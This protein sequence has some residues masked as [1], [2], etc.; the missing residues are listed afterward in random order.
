MST[1][2]CIRSVL[3]IKE[4]RRQFDA[5]DKD[6]SGEIDAEEAISVGGAT[7]EL[8]RADECT[9]ADIESP[10]AIHKPYT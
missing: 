1:P 8:K 9:R 6:A 7:D 2:S 4:L 3:H 10:Q 5:A